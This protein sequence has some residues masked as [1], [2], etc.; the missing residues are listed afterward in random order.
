MSKDL[1]LRYFLNRYCYYHYLKRCTYYIVADYHAEIGPDDDV[2]GGHGLGVGLRNGRGP[3]T[4]V[5][6][7]S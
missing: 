7:Q 4:A 6:A 2:V 1:S 3:A 5:G